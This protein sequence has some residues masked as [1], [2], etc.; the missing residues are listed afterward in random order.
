[1]S[2]T[3]TNYNIL[4]YAKECKPKVA[5]AQDHGDLV[6]KLKSQG[7]PT[8]YLVLFTLSYRFSR[9]TA[10]NVCMYL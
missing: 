7:H 5:D 3:L 6:V 4:T 2:Y 9:H 10:Y 1:M 8:P